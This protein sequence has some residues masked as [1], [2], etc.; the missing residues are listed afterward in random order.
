VTAVKRNYDV[1]L[2]GEETIDGRAC[3]HL[4]LKP[5]GNPGTYRVRELYV[6]EA[7]NQTVRLR[8]DGNFT[9]KATGSGS[10]TVNYAELDG[11]WYLADETSDGP[12][13]SDDGDF[14]KVEVRFVDIRS[15]VRENLDFGVPGVEDAQPLVEPAD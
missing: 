7:T 11:S 14:D 9:A 6:E 13:A 15:D 8:T 3:W 5:L 2:A 10:W 12:V 1:R 4:T